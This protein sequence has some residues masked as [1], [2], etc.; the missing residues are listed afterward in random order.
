MS[1]NISTLDL[2]ETISL[3]GSKFSTLL[4]KDSVSPLFEIASIVKKFDRTD[5][6]LIFQE[7]KGYSDFVGVSNL[8]NTRNKIRF[9]LGVD[10]DVELYRKI[11]AAESNAAKGNYFDIVSSPDGYKVVEDFDICVLPFALFYEFEP[12]PYIT[13]G[14]VAIKD[15]SGFINLSIH[16]ISVLDKNKLVIRIVPRHLFAIWRKYCEEGLESVPVAVYLGVSPIVHIAAASSPPFGVSE[17]NMIYHLSGVRPKVY[18]DDKYDVPVLI[19]ADI[20]LICE[21]SCSERDVEGPYV[22]VLG[23]YDDVRREPVL[24]VR[25]A[26]VRSDVSKHIMYY[27]VPALSEHR[28]LMSVEK[29]AKIWQYVSSVVPEVKAVRLTPGGGSWLHAIIAIKKQ[30]DGDAKNAII[31]AFAAHPSL[32]HVVIVDSDIDVDSPEEVEWAI[33]TRF[34][35]D[36]DLVVIKYVRGSTLDP[37]SIDQTSGLTVK[38][39]VDAT[40]P[41]DRSRS[42][43]ERAR[44][45]VD[46]KVKRIEVLTLPDMLYVL[47]KIRRGN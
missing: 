2:Y 25:R 41:L 18:F 26:Y 17:L 6:I 44:I 21:L 35:A 23:L 9:L 16:R 10:S 30:T 12:R 36:E 11:L 40:V 42:K 3:L 1:S 4:I 20:V 13:S 7:L 33:A 45:P 43:F 38:V 31:A 27:I 29:E 32:K 39:G 28:L 24:R 8:V 34:R 19:G 14:I 47:E 46:A 15:K 37:S 5:N 22:D